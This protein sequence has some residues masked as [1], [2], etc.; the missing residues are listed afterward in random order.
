M[1]IVSTNHPI[2]VNGVRESKASDYLSASGQSAPD[3]YYSA[4]G[5]T[6]IISSKNPIV[7]DGKNLSNPTWYLAEGDRMSQKRA[8]NVGR[9]IA[10]LTREIKNAQARIDSINA[11]VSASGNPMG[12]VDTNIIRGLTRQIGRQQAT[13]DKLMNM[14]SSS[15]DGDD[16]Y[17]ADAVPTV[18]QGG[19]PTANQVADAKK[20]GLFW[21]KVKNTWVKAKEGGVLDWV[22]GLFGLNVPPAFQP[23]QTQGGGQGG[24]QGGNTTPPPPPPMNK[25]TKTLLIVGGALVVGFIIYS[26]AKPRRNGA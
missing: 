17:G 12:S 14:Q 1:K 7:V 8:D 26:V 25:T 11:R 22:G 20:K 15:A 13:L 23:T 24:N 2:I 5:L 18:P 3:D 16:Y 4:D 21:D 9:R 10:K 19:T 6:D